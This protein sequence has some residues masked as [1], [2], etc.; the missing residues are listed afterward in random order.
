MST[1]TISKVLVSTPLIGDGF[2]K[3][4]KGVEK[5]EKDRNIFISSRIIFSSLPKS[6][7]RKN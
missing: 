1:K 6:V 2:L 7:G 3:K 5:D 4:Q